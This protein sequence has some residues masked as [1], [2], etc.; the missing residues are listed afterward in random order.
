MI[1]QDSEARYSNYIGKNDGDFEESATKASRF[2]NDENLKN[3][4]FSQSYRTFSEK[5]TTHR[6]EMLYQRAMEKNAQRYCDNLG[7]RTQSC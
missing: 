6:H 5:R 7:E 4:S 3:S 1:E 2:L